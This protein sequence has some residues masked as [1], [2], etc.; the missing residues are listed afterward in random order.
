[1]TEFPRTMVGGVSL[2]R[3]IVGTN[4]FLGFSHATVAKDSFIKEHNCTPK[5][6]ADMLE[7]FF[8]AGIDAVMGPIEHDPLYDGIREAE[9]RTG[10]KALLISTPPLPTNHKTPAEG[11]DLE[12][13]HSTASESIQHSVDEVATWF[14]VLE[15]QVEGHEPECQVVPNLTSLPIR[16]A[17]DPSYLDE[18][19]AEIGPVFISE[20]TQLRED[21]IRRS[22]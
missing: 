15:H 17:P 16:L 21:S 4:W 11:L 10:V 6:I 22:P 14:A 13:H 1:M 8:R 7:V 5:R 3:M 9:S 18:S 20:T 2:S 12:H 19:R